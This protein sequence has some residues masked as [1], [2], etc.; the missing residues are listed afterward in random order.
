MIS[1]VEVQ[2]WDEGRSDNDST[3]INLT[4]SQVGFNTWHI[5]LCCVMCWSHTLNY[6][7]RVKKKYRETYNVLIL[8]QT[9]VFR[10]FSFWAHGWTSSPGCRTWVWMEL[11]I[12]W[13]RTRTWVWRL[14]GVGGLPI[15]ITRWWWWWWWWRW[16]WTVTRSTVS[17]HRSVFAA[18]ETKVE[19]QLWPNVCALPSFITLQWCRGWWRECMNHMPINHKSNCQLRWC[20]IYL[21]LFLPWQLTINNI[22]IL[23]L[24]SNS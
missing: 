24:C 21:F 17:S 19:T 11:P 4:P 7:K 10:C 8:H 1:C 15:R 22:I 2:P 20:I 9:P 6:S 14:I 3:H 23:V 13:G 5:T 18:V 16:W 12:G